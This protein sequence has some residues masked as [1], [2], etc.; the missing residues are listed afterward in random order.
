[1]KKIISSLLLSVSCFAFPVEGYV[2]FGQFINCEIYNDFNHSIVVRDYTY[3]IRLRNG[4]YRNVS[5]TCGYNCEVRPN[6]FNNFSGPVN[7]PL[8]YDASCSANVVRLRR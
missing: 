8:V 7:S 2:N 3:S 5:Y 1:M 4:M 6:S